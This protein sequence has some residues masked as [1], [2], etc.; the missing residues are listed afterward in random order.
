MCIGIS[1]ILCMSVGRRCDVCE[2]V[3]AVLVLQNYGLEGI[4]EVYL[5]I[6]STQMYSKSAGKQ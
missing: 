1:N 6:F 5:V 3:V 4:S 2:N